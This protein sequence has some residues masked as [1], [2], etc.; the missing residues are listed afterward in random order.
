MEE[1]AQLSCK[2]TPNSDNNQLKYSYGES[3]LIF[4]YFGANNSHLRYNI[5]IYN[6]YT[7]GVQSMD[8]VDAAPP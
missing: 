4:Y 5:Y 1:D 2:I 7:N 8:A 6:M 3:N